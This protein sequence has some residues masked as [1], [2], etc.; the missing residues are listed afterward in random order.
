MKNNKFNLN[1]FQS[2]PYKNAKI[3]GLSKYIG[4]YYWA[5]RFYG[6]IIERITPKRGKILEIG[7]GFGDLLSFL[8]KDFQTVG[9]DVSADAIKEA[10][11]K[12]KNTTLE[13]L[14]AEEI[15]KLDKNS[16]DTVIASHTLE[17][18]KKPKVVIRL[19]SKL[20]KTNG[21]FFIVVPNPDSVGRK[22]KGKNWVGYRDK[23]HI[24]LFTPDKWFKLLEYEGFIIEK[25]FGDGLWDSPYFPFIPKIIQQAILGLSA[26][27]QTLVN[28]PFI[29]INLGE[30][31][32]I[33]VR[34]N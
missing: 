16:F 24:S 26:V 8:E 9:T 29:P 17:H 25:A 23:T 11:K 22:L 1:Y 14:A 30:S 19:V 33:L 13:I 3:S 32:I 18:L 28:I 7:C 34:K 21:I 5:R 15:G 27:V 6:K 31:I 12:L 4:K 10:R 20:L 2:G